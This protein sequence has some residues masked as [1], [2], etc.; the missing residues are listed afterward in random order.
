[1]RIFS[2]SCFGTARRRNA[3]AIAL[4]LWCVFWLWMW[5]MVLSEMNVR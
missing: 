3:R 2:S 4:D 1:M 5:L